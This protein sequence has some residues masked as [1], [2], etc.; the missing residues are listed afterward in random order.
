[1]VFASSSAVWRFP[2][3]FQ[4]FWSLLTIATIW[5]NPESPRY[6]YAKDRVQ[7]ADAILERMY[8]RTLTDPHVNQ[9]K[10]EILA[11][12]ELEKA[13]TAR[14]RFLDFFWDR[15]EMQA[16]RRIRTGMILV[17]VAY[18]MGIDMI[19][20]YMTTIFESY[21]GLKPLTASGLAGA[22]TTVLCIGNYIGVYFMEKFGRRTWLIAGAAGQTVFLAAFTGLLSHPGSKTGAA[23]AAM[24]FL[25]IVVFSPTWGPVTVSS[26]TASKGYANLGIVCLF[27]RDHASPLSPYRVLTQCFLP[28]AH[29]I[30]D[31]V[32]W[33]H[34]HCRQKCRMEDLDL[35][36]GFQLHRYSI[37]YV[38]VP[39]WH[40]F[41]DKQQ[42]TFVAPK[43][44]VIPLKRLT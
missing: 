31:R 23:A 6:Y 41:T 37:R 16:A 30:L 39:T 34:C 13:D 11:S 21:I 35:V 44:V 2:V 18:L 26:L 7:E 5:S 24:L 40:S 36:L 4:I 42:F 15:S 8:G 43:P 20:Y 25:W 9:A 28:M 33:S 19:F 17:G 12:L 38:Y 10:S 3:A 22:A 14:L 27:I 29:G 1:M 32:R